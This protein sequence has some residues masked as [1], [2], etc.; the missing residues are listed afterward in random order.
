MPYRRRRAKRATIDF[1]D[2][3]VLGSGCD[4]GQDMHEVAAMWSYGRE[5]VL[6]DFI[7]RHPGRR[8]W[9]WWCFDAEDPPPYGELSYPDRPEDDSGDWESAHYHW[10]SQ[11]EVRQ[12][13]EWAQE[14]AQLRYLAEGGHLEPQEIEYLL[15]ESEQS[16]D[17][18]CHRTGRALT[19]YRWEDALQC[20]LIE[21]HEVIDKPAVRAQIVR[22]A[23]AA[24][25]PV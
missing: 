21:R 24:R 1:L 22:E 19:S 12:G 25:E 23:L 9:A 2:E 4:H 20:G 15:A 7:E 18:I 13:A 3:L 14:Q 5:E 10:L 16:G 17:Q 11:L 8:P 6:A